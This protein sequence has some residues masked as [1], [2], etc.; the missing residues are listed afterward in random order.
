MKINPIYTNSFNSAQRFQIK[1]ALEWL[2]MVLASDEFKWKARKY[3][4][5]DRY[6][7][8][9]DGFTVNL[10]R[11]YPERGNRSMLY[12]KETSTISVNFLQAFDFPKK[13]MAST[14]GHEIGHQWFD[15]SALDLNSFLGFIQ[16]KVKYMKGRSNL[17][18]KALLWIHNVF[19]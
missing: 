11:L 7:E 19:K 9:I 14:L 2:C 4:E 3:K 1:E 5:R 10:K 18:Y 8:N 13:Q 15:H 12:F 17:Y 6:L 16:Y